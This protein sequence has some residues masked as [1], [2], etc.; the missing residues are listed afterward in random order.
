MEFNLGIKDSDIEGL[1]DEE[2]SELAEQ[3]RRFIMA[4][5]AKI[6]EALKP[7]VNLEGSGIPP[8]Q[9][10]FEEDVWRNDIASGKI[11]WVQLET[12]QEAK[13]KA[14]SAESIVATLEQIIYTHKE[15]RARMNYLHG[16]PIA[17]NDKEEDWIF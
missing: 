9:F 4:E 17:E 8:R 13:L 16:E 1:P 2:L 5:E 3:G 10:W 11:N 12:A 14:V 6:V 7:R 15:H